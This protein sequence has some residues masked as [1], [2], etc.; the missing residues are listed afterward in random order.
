MGIG[1]ILGYF[2]LF[3]NCINNLTNG[4]GKKISNSY[5]GNVIKRLWKKNISFRILTGDVLIQHS[6]NA[7]QI[8]FTQIE[9]SN[10]EKIGASKIEGYYKS[11]PN[12][13]VKLKRNQLS[14]K[15]L[16]NN[17][18]IW[19]LEVDEDL[20]NWDEIIFVVYWEYV[21]NGIPNKKKREYKKNCICEEP[22]E[23]VIKKKEQE[24]IQANK[25]AK[26]KLFEKIVIP[27]AEG[28]LEEIWE[29]LKPVRDMQKKIT[30]ATEPTHK[31]IESINKSL[32]PF[33]EA[34]RKLQEQLE[35]YYK[36]FQDN[37]IK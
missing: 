13:K 17:K 15:E 29:Q 31:T 30:E 33:Y 23:F 11:T 1:E 25:E 35:P 21:K 3:I 20:V 26:E 36:I 27:N 28:L 32:E 5:I 34:Q 10:F 24:L 18:A 22:F 37:T 2:S 14:P 16:K 19:F 9:G 8:T 12:K 4:A 7:L 6:S